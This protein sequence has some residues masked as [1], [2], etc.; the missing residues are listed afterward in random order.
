MITGCTEEKQCAA[1]VKA[2]EAI[3]ALVEELYE[4]GKSDS[5]AARIG[6]LWL[7]EDWRD[8]PFQIS[9]ASPKSLT[10]SN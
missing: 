6:E 10:R 3:N 9:S 1:F 2:E 7:K 4:C 5:D 8:H